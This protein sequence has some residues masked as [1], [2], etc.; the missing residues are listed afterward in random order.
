MSFLIKK[1]ISYPLL[2][3]NSVSIAFSF[4]FLTPSAC[5]HPVNL[6][7]STIRSLNIGSL[8]SPQSC[9]KDFAEGCCKSCLIF[10]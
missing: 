4:P 7:L 1:N 8:S 9:K 6:E 10:H 3:K 5:E 2:K